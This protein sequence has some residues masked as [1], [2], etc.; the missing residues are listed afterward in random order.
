MAKARFGSV[1]EYVASQREGARDILERVRRAIRRALPDAEESISYSIPTYKL[2]GSAVLYFAGWK[3]YYSIYPCGDAVV[4]QFREELAPYAVQKATVRFRY[5]IPVP[6][7]LIEG[8]A[9]F[10]A[11]E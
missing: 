7:K 4:T 11:A 6:E 9:V 2:N 3:T 1:D 10:R 8:I 5:S